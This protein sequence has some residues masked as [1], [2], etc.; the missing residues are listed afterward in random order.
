VAIFYL[1]ALAKKRIGFIEKQD[2]SAIFGR[3]E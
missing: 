2:G 3:V 1:T